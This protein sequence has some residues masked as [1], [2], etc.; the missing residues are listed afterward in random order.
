MNAETNSGEMTVDTA[1]EAIQCA[2]AGG[3][4]AIRYDGNN[5]VVKRAVAE[6]LEALGDSFAYQGEI[7]EGPYAGRI[8]TIPVN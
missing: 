3:G 5:L 8:V 7:R 6:Q 1:D 4:E 2:E